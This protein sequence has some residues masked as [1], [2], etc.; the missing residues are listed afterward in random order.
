MSIAMMTRAEKNVAIRKLKQKIDKE[1]I[2]EDVKIEYEDLKSKKMKRDILLR[3][4][5]LLNEKVMKLT[6]L[7]NDNNY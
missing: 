1:I 2:S 4:L 3:K 7:R 5:I 6:I